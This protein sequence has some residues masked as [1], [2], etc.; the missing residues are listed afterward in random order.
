PSLDR[1]V[2]RTAGHCA[3]AGALL[4]DWSRQLLESVL[5]RQDQ[6]LLL[7]KW[8]VYTDSQ[9]RRLLRMWLRHRGLKPPSLALLQAIEQQVIFARADADPYVSMQDFQ[10]RRYRQKLFCL[11]ARYWR[12]GAG[13]REWDGQADSM[14]LGN[15][16][17][18]TRTISSCGL[19]QSL[20]HSHT[21]R[22]A[23]RQGGEKL[24]LPGRSGHHCLKKLY[25]EAG[26]PPWERNVRPLVYLNDRLAAVAGLWV[27]EWAWRQIPDGCYEISWRTDDARLHQR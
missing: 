16:W 11:P 1:T 14:T 7:D 5:D 21:V 4:D 24:K 12:T 6:S 25:Q 23:Y 9:R 17:K 27:A 18:L 22:I 15:G 8:L 3:S 2:A 19:D 20:W 26:A 10:I 13:D